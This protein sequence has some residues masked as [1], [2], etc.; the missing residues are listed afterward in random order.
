MY[1]V[2]LQEHHVHV[3]SKLQQK[4]DTALWDIGEDVS[5]QELAPRRNLFTRVL[6]RR[7][8]PEPSQDEQ[9]ETNLGDRGQGEH[10]QF[11]CV[12]LVALPMA[13]QDRR[14]Q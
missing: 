11:D 10:G 12:T 4:F 7:L 13:T 2:H 6:G 8:L 5:T 3:G 9:I 14:Y 1:A